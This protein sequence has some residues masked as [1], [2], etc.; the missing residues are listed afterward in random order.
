MKIIKLKVL[1]CEITQSKFANRVWLAVN[2]DNKASAQFIANQAGGL[3]SMQT[4]MYKKMLSDL[5]ELKNCVLSGTITSK[6]NCIN[7]RELCRKFKL[8]ENKLNKIT[9]GRG[10]R[11]FIAALK[12]LGHTP[13]SFYK[14]AEAVVQ[15]EYREVIKKLKELT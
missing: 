15:L 9:F 8:E 11:D 14:E 10:H 4:K 3:G 13:E 1:E 6:N 12:K 7:K 2:K 5:E